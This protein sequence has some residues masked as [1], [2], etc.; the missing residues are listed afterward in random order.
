[1]PTER[2]ERT[3]GLRRTVHDE[4]PCGHCRVSDPSP[5]GRGGRHWRQHRERDGTR[6]CNSCRSGPPHAPKRISLES[7]FRSAFTRHRRME[8]VWGGSRSCRASGGKP[9]S[10]ILGTSTNVLLRL[11]PS[12]A[13]DPEPWCES[14]P[15][16]SHMPSMTLG[17]CRASRL[18]G[19]NRT[20]GIPP[21]VAGQVGTLSGVRG[22]L[23]VVN[24]VGS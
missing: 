18:S 19:T 1:M 8:D 17:H 23:G 9:E 3:T 11:L 12:P 10:R 21:H 4:Q 2:D 13:V 15:H 7:S 16:L 20:L 14:P 24:G 6:C 5:R 22:A